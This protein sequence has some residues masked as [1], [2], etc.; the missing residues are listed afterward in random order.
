MSPRNHGLVRCDSFNTTCTHFSCAD[1]RLP[2]TRLHLLANFK[3]MNLVR[4]LLMAIYI[5]ALLMVVGTGLLVSAWDFVT[6]H[7]CWVAVLM[8]LSFY[9]CNKILVYTYLLERVHQLR[10]TRRSKDFIWYIGILVIFGGF[11]TI[12]VFAFL[13]PVDESSKV[14]GRCRIGL[15][16]KSTIL[17]I[18]YDAAINTALT[19]VFLVQA[20]QWICDLP[21]RSQLRSMVSFVSNAFRKMRTTDSAEVY[22]TE[23]L[24]VM[25]S[26]SLFGAIIIVLPTLANLIILLYMNGHEQGWLCFTTCVLDGMSSPTYSNHTIS[27]V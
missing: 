16:N 3:D 11:G 10:D 5:C 18:G 26:K 15:H 8:C 23:V 4:F 12:A 1:H 14:D 20:Y 27:E 6:I 17:L 13:K 25:M 24:K 2:A 22:K 19:A 9:V 21:F 7:L